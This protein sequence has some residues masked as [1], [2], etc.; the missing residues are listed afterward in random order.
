MLT[1]EA[2]LTTDGSTTIPSGNHTFT[3]KEATPEALLFG[4]FGTNNS[5]SYAPGTE[6]AVP[7]SVL[8]SGASAGVTLTIGLVSRAVRRL[9]PRSAPLHLH[10]HDQCPQRRHR[11]RHAR[12]P[13]L[14]NA[15]VRRDLYLDAQQRQVDTSP[16]FEVT[17]SDADGN[18]TTI[19]PV[20]ISVILGLVPIS[21]PVEHHS[22]WKRS[23]YVL[24]VPG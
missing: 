19:G 22:R 16:A 13:S 24:R 8:T 7:Q 18:S 11:D 14:G 4:D 12:D 15:V 17:V 9:K 2:A 3:V 21:V 10:R 20:N 5:G 6:Y 23:R 1:L